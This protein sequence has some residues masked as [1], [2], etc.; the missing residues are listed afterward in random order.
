MDAVVGM[1]GYGP[2]NGSPKQVGLILSGANPYELDVVASTAIG[3]E[4]KKVPSIRKCIERGYCTGKVEDVETVGEKLRDVIVA[5]FDKPTTKVAFNVYD[6]FLP[7][8]IAKWLNR[9]LKAKPG[10]KPAACRGCGICAKSCPAKAI[11]MKNGKPSVDLGKCISCF[12]CHELCNYDAVDIKRPWVMKV[13]L[14]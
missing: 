4:P 10:F 6:W 9:R 5:D 14:K 13:L 11:E 1:E 2:T 12:C 7:K 8:F 3:L